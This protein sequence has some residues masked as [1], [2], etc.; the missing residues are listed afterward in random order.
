MRPGPGQA[1][2]SPFLAKSGNPEDDD[3]SA[4][5]VAPRK[6]LDNWHNLYKPHNSD[7]KVWF[8]GPYQVFAM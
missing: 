3:E 6:S 5:F 7:L 1:D 2:C 4:D 8:C